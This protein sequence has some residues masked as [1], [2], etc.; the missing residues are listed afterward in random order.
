M[1][2]KTNIAR[3]YFYT[4]LG[5]GNYVA[6]WLGASAYLTIIYEFV[7]KD[8]MPPSI[9][10]YAGLF[11]A[12]MI[13]SLAMGYEMKKLK[14]YGEEHKINTETNPYINIPIGAKEIVN[15]KTSIASLKA[16]IEFYDKQGIDTK[17]LKELMHEQEELLKKA[18]K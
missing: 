1:A 10:L 16:A 12:I 2:L 18:V 15:Y 17:E 6:W 11:I 14:V 8:F 9:A 3:I 4:K 5:W 7:L 13:F